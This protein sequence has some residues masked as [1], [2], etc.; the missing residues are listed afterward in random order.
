M[1]GTN[2]SATRMLTSYSPGRLVVRLIHLYMALR[3]ALAK[4]A[5]G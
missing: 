1:I 3:I 2:A 5:L 4:Y